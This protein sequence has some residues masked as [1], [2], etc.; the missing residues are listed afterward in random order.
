MVTTNGNPAMD[1]YNKPRDPSDYDMVFL[2]AKHLEEELN[3]KNAGNL[4]RGDPIIASVVSKTSNVQRVMIN[5]YFTNLLL[6]FRSKKDVNVTDV[7]F[8]LVSDGYVEDWFTL[9]RTYVIPFLNT[10]NVYEV[11]YS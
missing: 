10:N 11:A 1:E 2:V 7:L 9:F 5:R 8:Y 3:N 6:V 4:F